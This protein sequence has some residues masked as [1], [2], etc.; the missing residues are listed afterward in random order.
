MTIHLIKLCVGAETVADLQV[1]VDH[2]VGDRRRAR[3]SLLSHHDT[4][5]WP[6]RA[7]EVL[8]GGSLY[9]VIKGAVLVRQKIVG[10]EEI[11]PGDGR[12]M[13]RIWLDPGLVRTE[14]RGRRP[15]QGWRYLAPED[16]PPDLSGEA[17]QLSPELVA[18]LKQS[19]AW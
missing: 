10:L 13:C 17:S 6:K 16:A 5:M 7:E 8:Q 3:L 9:W 15:F 2:L 18:A 11:D 14:P 19:L 1:W 4:R 12:P